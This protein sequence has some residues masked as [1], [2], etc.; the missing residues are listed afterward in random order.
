MFQNI[1]QSILVK[2]VL[3]E[4]FHYDFWPFF[5]LVVPSEEALD[6]PLCWLFLQSFVPLPITVIYAECYLGNAKTAATKTPP[7]LSKMGRL[8]GRIS[9]F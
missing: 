3:E 7:T 9:V 4:G 5:R 1:S 2:C 8:L 6:R